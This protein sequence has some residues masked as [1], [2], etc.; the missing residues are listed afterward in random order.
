MTN[1]YFCGTY[2]D[3]D[4]PD[5]W[6]RQAVWVGGPK[7]NNAKLAESTGELGHDLCVKKAAAG[8]APDQPEIE[9]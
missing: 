6:K 9:F 3:P 2:V 5:T 1:C 7:K 4:A 8:H